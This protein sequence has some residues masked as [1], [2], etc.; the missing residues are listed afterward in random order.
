MLEWLRDVL[1]GKS[2]AEVAV[3]LTAAVYSIRDFDK[4]SA[5]KKLLIVATSFT[6]AFV[7]VDPTMEYMKMGDSWRMLV[8]FVLAVSA[9]LI[10]SL[11]PLAAQKA[12]EKIEASK[13]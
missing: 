7:A 1:A 12:R 3:V 10:L 13:L 11:L 2:L 6:L 5:A 8:L 9:H 4:I